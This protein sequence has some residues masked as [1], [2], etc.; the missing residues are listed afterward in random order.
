MI[1]F[2]IGMAVATGLSLLPLLPHPWMRVRDV[3][4]GRVWRQRGFRRIAEI[5]ETGLRDAPFRW[6]TRQPLPH[7]RNGTI[8][9]SGFAGTLEE[10]QTRVREVRASM[11]REQG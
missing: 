10:A 4:G 2:L 8:A 5:A 6:W 1:G 3:A 11:Q 7:G 9:C